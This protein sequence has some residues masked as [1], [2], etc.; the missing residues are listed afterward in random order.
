MVTCAFYYAYQSPN[1]TDD[2][3]DRI[4]FP[5]KSYN[6]IAPKS[7][8]IENMKS[9]F[10]DESSSIDKY[11]DVVLSINKAMFKYFAA[12]SLSGVKEFFMHKYL[13]KD[14]LAFSNKTT[15]DAL[16]EITYNQ[17]L[18]GVLTGQWGDYGLPPKQ[19]SFAM[20]CAI[21]GHYL[22]G[23]NYPIGGSRMIA[24]SIAPVIEKYD[25]KI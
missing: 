23:A 5:D 12:K 1:K 4:I 20:H 18:I 14:F 6:F 9:Y 21:A 8:F 13:T 25:G 17:K 22:D 2:N 3:Y 16:S 10:P 7:K 15:Y 24:E 11:I 19:S